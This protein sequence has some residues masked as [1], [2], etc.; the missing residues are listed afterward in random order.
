MTAHRHDLGRWAIPAKIVAL[1][2]AIVV[3]GLYAIGWL[4]VVPLETLI[5]QCRRAWRSVMDTRPGWDDN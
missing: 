2:V 5:R 4:L 1:P 3:F